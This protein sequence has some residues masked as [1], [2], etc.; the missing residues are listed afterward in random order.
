MRGSIVLLTASVATPM[1]P[2]REALLQDRSIALSGDVPE[3]VVD[4]LR[5]LGAQVSKLDPAL[6]MDEEA[7]SAWA[8]ATGPFDALICGQGANDDLL[9]ETWAAV[10]ALTIETFIPRSEGRVVML[11]PRDAGGV[12]AALENMA[13]TLSVEWARFAVTTVAIAPSAATTD[14]ELA[15][16]AAFLCSPAGAYFSGCRIELGLVE[17]RDRT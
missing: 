17:R 10:R 14:E 3:G 5:A 16:L 9:A 13:R 8:R 6:S 7:M 12:A 2:F 1:H 4:V 15:Q 11:T